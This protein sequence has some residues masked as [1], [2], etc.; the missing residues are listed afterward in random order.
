MTNL[1]IGLFELLTIANTV[2]IA[3]ISAYLI[4]G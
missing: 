2:A 4:F 3:V 1:S